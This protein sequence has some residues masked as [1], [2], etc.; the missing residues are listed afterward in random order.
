MA[1]GYGAALA[2]AMLIYRHSNL[3]GLQLDHHVPD[4]KV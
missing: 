3:A 2:R 1:E 4:D